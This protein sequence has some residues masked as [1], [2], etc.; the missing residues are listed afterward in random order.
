MILL[1]LAVLFGIANAFS[2]RRII[3]AGLSAAIGAGLL[4]AILTALTALA[5]A[6]PPY[7]VLDRALSA[8]A[9]D[10][11]L[12]T[13]LA[14]AGCAAVATGLMLTRLRPEEWSPDQPDRR[15]GDDRRRDDRLN[16][17]DRRREKIRRIIRDA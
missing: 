7:S 4:H 10:L 6:N 17:P 5:A 1:C 13:T 8:I 11:P 9:G 3:T 2:Y 16:G 12:P 14:A 15:S